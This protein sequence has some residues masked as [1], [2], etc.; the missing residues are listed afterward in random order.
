MD[1]VFEYF[2]NITRNAELL[3]IETGKYFIITI[4]K[5]STRF[6]FEITIN[7]ECTASQH[8]TSI[9]RYYFNGVALSG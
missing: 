5:S 8:S 3:Y 1:H 2:H 9:Q 7:Y 6:S 4:I